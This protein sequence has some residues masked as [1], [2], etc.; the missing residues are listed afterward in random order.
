IWVTADDKLVERKLLLK[1]AFSR[2]RLFEIGRQLGIPYFN[3]FASGWEIDEEEASLEIASNINDAQLKGIFKEYNPREW[4]VFRGKYYTFENGNLHLNGYWKTLRVHIHQ[5]R[6]KYGRNCLAILTT[7]LKAGG[8]CCVEDFA[9]RLKRG[10]DP[11]PI[12][13]ELERLKIIVTS[14]RGDQYQEWKILEE[15]SPLVQLE[16]GVAPPAPPHPKMASPPTPS[17]KAEKMD[18][19]TL[20]R[21]LVEEMDRKLDEYINNLLKHRLRRTVRFGRKFSIGTLA[22]YLQ[23][24]F[25]PLLYFDSLLAITQQ[26]GLADVEI[27]HSQGKT[28]IRTGWSLALFG[29]AGTGKSFS[30]RD[31][32]LGKPNAKIPPHGVP[33]R[34]RYCGGMTPA[35]FIRIGQAYAGRTFN[36][37]VPEFNDWFRYPGMVDVLKI[38]MERGDI[39]YELHREA[40]GPYR[41][42]S[43]L[44][45]NYNTTVFGRGYEVT[46]SDPHFNAIEDR[47]VCRLH[48][49][50]KRRFIEIAQSQMKLALGEI[51]IE[52]GAKDI[53]DHVALVYAIETRHPL[54]RDRFPYKPVMLTPQVYET[55]KRAREA[56][57]EHIPHEVVRFSARLEDRAIRFACAASLLD[58]FH[59]DMDFIPVS[60]EALRYAVQLYVE[61]ASV[62]SREEFKPEEVLENLC[63]AIE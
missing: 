22:K 13:T 18:Y 59:S 2:V 14:Y 30:T 15:V 39:K 11:R 21:Q 51:D 24:L 35:R 60:K 28:G 16:L 42:N 55:I 57:L 56:I 34:N 5:A 17:V 40:I 41:F 31:M 62:R 1:R 53:R 4:V 48:R 52:K 29:E 47:M 6:K 23:E 19:V 50:T 7:L 8:S 45:V 36:F 38:A 25:G 44:S 43:F 12:L 27:V 26:Y 9:K 46:I 3:R 20:E 61:E 32:I 54:V 33:G 63:D 10:V 58:Y 49:L 37:I